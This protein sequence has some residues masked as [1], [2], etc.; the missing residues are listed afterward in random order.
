M[1]KK[2]LTCALAALVPFAVA[3]GGGSS[4]KAPSTPSHATATSGQRPTA[5]PPPGYQWVG[6]TSQHIWLAVPASWVSIDLSKVSI[7]KALAK[8]SISGLESGTLK[9]DVESLAQRHA[10]FM[11]DLGSAATSPNHFASNAS[12]FCSA[13][14]ILPGAGAMRTLDSG[15]RAEYASLHVRVLSL[16]NNAATSSK[17]V[18]TA[19]LTARTTGGYSL[20]ELQVSDLTSGGRLCELTMTTDRPEAFL[21]TFTTIASTLQVS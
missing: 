21:T 17:D 13:T 20:T 5:A 11:A 16:R 14:P 7:P 6:S 1:R 19:E 2:L 9:A 10:L 15:L 12:A 8:F 3:C 4:S 18:V